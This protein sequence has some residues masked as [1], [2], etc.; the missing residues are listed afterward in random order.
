MLEEAGAI[1]MSAIQH[2]HECRVLVDPDT[3]AFSETIVSTR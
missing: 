1:C 2:A 3:W